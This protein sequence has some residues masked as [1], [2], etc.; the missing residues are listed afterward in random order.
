MKQILF[1]YLLI[2]LPVIVSGQ[3]QT[4]YEVGASIAS[5]EPGNEVFSLALAGYGYPSEGRFSITWTETDSLPPDASNEEIIQNEDNAQV[6]FISVAR[7]K[8][9]LYALGD[10]N[11]LYKKHL[12]P[13]NTSWVKAGYNNKETYTINIKRI[14]VANDGLYA[15]DSDDKIYVAKHNSKGN[16]SARS[17]VVKSGKNTVALVSVDL[18]GFDYTFTQEV[19]KEI[20]KKT[21]I[22]VEA[23]LINATHT[24]F[25]PVPQNYPSWPA[26]GQHPDP[27]YLN[28][29]VKE[30]IVSSVVTALKNLKKSTI[31]VGRSQSIIGKNRALSGVDGLYDPTLDV[32]AFE[33]V[34]KKDKSVLFINACHPVFRNEGKERYT[35]S[36]NFPGVA[37]QFVEDNTSVG[38]AIFFQGCASDINPLSDN[39]HELGETLARDVIKTLNEPM[40]NI[41]GPVSFS[42]DSVLFP[43]YPWSVEKFKEFHAQNIIKPGDLDAEKNV[44]WAERMLSLYEKDEM[45]EVMPVYIQTINIGNWKFVGLSREAVTEYSLKIRE[46]WPDKFVSVASYCND[47]ASYLPNA[48]HVRANNYE[49][50]GSFLWYSSPAF[51]PE[52]TLDILVDYIKK[53]NK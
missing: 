26:F 43:V 33:S 6:R 31:S 29:V 40:R 23:I 10:D 16:L 2:L 32:I 49:G 9:Q 18:C 14:A 28:E 12:A 45:P 35:M 34:D 27:V 52:N 21:K 46:L 13:Y 50:F 39:Y 5:I 48:A 44:R 36:A 17:I 42:V 53:Q 1:F 4:V 7:Y 47:V 38:N 11:I 25:A 8:N 15:V 37:K 24:H 22:P 20:N 30:G 41:S 3:K 19:K 51:F